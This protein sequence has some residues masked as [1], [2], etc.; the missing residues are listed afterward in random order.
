[1]EGATAC[2]TGS[3]DSIAALEPHIQ[4]LTPNA[5]AFGHR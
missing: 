3:G 1:M 4:R 2:Q 5:S